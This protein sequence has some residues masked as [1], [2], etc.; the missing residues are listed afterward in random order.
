LG[1]SPAGLGK[2][3]IMWVGEIER[4]P[5]RV[6]RKCTSLALR[7]SLRLLVH[8]D[9]V[10]SSYDDVFYQLLLEW[11]L[12]NQL[13]EFEAGEIVLDVEARHMDVAGGHRP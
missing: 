10:V 4:G 9:L 8:Q 7:L 1:K 6:S 13:L 3:V 12:G 11:Q 2:K 5:R